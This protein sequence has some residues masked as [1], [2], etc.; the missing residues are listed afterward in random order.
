M[1]FSELKDAMV[2]GHKGV[3]HFDHKPFIMKAWNPK[4]DMN[5]DAIVS[6]PRWI[7][8]HELDI[9]SWGM[10]SLS[11]IGSI[12]GISLKIDKYTKEKSML[13]YARL[14]VEM[15]LERH[16]PKYIQFANEKDVIII[17]KVEAN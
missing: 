14:L 8:L 4:M 6:L 17:Q 5:I 2:V 7:Q 1:R 15:P 13:K 12:L 11:K 3:F 9:K 16:F 10:Q